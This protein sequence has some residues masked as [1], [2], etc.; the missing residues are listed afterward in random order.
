[1]AL[2][3]FV[4]AR[5][6]WGFDWEEARQRGLDIIVAIDT[7]K[8]MLAEDIAPNRLKR[9]K[10]AALDLLRLARTDRVGLVAFAGTAF[11][12]CPLSLDDEAFRQSVE[13]LDVS[14]IPQGGTAL[15][16]AIYTARSAFKEKNDNY[17]VLVLFTDGEDH[18]GHALEAAK[19][20]A[21]E[22]MRIFTVGVGTAN[23]EVLRT[24]DAKGRTDFIKD[25]EGNAVKS[26][27]N[28]SLLRQ[29]AEATDGFY[30]LLGGA[31]TMKLLYERR[32]A[33][34][35]KAE[36]A[37]R[38]IRRYHEHYQWFLGAAIA[39]LLVEV[40]IPERKRVPRTEAIVSAPNVEL[41][42][43][44]ALLALLAYPAFALASPSS[45]LKRYQKGRF[46]AALHEY[47]RLLEKQP[48]DPRLHY[49][50]GAAAYRVQDYEEA[51][52]H[53]QS[54][55][56]TPDLPFQQRAYYNLGNAQF[57]LGEENEDLDKKRQSWEQA[58]GSYE[59]ALKLDPKDADAKFNLDVVRQ[60]LEEL[61]QE[62][63]Q[64]QQQSKD[65]PQ[66]K[67]DQ[68][69]QQNQQGEQQQQQE[70]AQK[71]QKQDE[72]QKREAKPEPQEQPQSKPEEQQQTQPKEGSARNDKK[73]AEAQQ[74][75]KPQD[76][77]RKTD[78]EE[79][80]A[81]K[82]LPFRMNPQE[83]QQLLDMQKN[84]EK[85]MIF[86]PQIKTNRLD[87]VFKDW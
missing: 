56:T 32:L 60:K 43:A 61:K 4:L 45:A 62:Q 85:T 27:L 52:K 65:G 9:A 48:D 1:V 80:Q 8:S 64:Q 3:V 21:K 20:V 31:D 53:L 51:A 15:A 44:V 47:E 39:L 7:S 67:Q 78:G 55:L 72:Q 30:L 35:P 2:L 25:T 42:R 84:D 29:I 19:E 24:A 12:Q 86:L 59:S 69:S 71:D 5:P 74:G 77:G 23:G 57:R 46:D 70:Q 14:V 18:D 82:I 37:V 34:L 66:D 54:A 26:R 81:A 22:G 6:Q 38:R 50:A 16:E 13:A 10:L 58:A 33:P 76:E 87:R 79:A 63:Q 68:Q 49:N 11:L 41:R 73:E 40:F 17:K 28:E 36:F 75:S 83:A